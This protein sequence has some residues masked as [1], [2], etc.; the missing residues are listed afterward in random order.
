VSTGAIVIDG[1]T[2]A[3]DSVVHGIYPR[4]ARSAT[5]RNVKRDIF[6]VDA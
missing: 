1:G 5:S 6:G 3:A 2:L 4:A